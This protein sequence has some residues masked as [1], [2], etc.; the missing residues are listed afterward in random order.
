MSVRSCLFMASSHDRRWCQGSPLRRPRHATG[1]S[2]R[3]A[4]ATSPIAAKGPFRIAAVLVAVG[5][6]SAARADDAAA[7]AGQNMVAGRRI[8]FHGRAAAHIDIGLARGDEAEFQG[9]GGHA[10]RADRQDREAGLS[11]DVAMPAAHQG[12]Q[13]RLGGRPNLRPRAS[14]MLAVRTGRNARSPGRSSPAIQMRSH[15][16]SGDDGR[17]GRSPWIRAILTLYS[18][19]PWMKSPVPSR[20]STRKK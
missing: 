9:R 8:P 15:G 1:R 6:G 20:G 12:H 10:P 3:G 19:V 17:Q 4:R 13:I 11:G 18:P 2:S 14:R 16:R 7:R 5:E